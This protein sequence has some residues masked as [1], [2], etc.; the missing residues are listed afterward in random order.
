MV[1]AFLI[2]FSIMAYILADKITNRS[3]IKCP[4]SSRKNDRKGTFSFN[5]YGD[6]LKEI[7]QTSKRCY[8]KIK[9]EI[10]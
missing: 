6:D 5:Y 10:G 7:L 3:M 4:K 9:K 8:E 1:L 2:I